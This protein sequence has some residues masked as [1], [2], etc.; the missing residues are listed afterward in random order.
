MKDLFTPGTSLPKH[1][2]RVALHGSTDAHG[3]SSRGGCQR[4]RRP[5]GG[6][7][8]GTPKNASSTHALEPRCTPVMGPPVVS[9]TPVSALAVSSVAGKRPARRVAASQVGVEV[10]RAAPR[11]RHKDHDTGLMN[12][13]GAQQGTRPCAA[14]LSQS[15]SRTLRCDEMRCANEIA[16]RKLDLEL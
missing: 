7:A 13:E 10:E 9:M 6:A 12:I 15:P 2:G 3:S 11:A 4:P 1:D 8:Y 14:T 5:V 16:A